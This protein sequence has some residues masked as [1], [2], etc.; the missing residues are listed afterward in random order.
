MTLSAQAAQVLQLIERAGNPEY[1][2]MTAREARAAHESRAGALDMAPDPLSH[3]VDVTLPG[4]GAPRPARV[5]ASHAPGPPLPVVLWL[6]GGGHTVGSVRSYDAVCR[7]LA[8]DSDCLVVSLEYRLAPEHKFPAA[9]DDAWAALEWL[10]RHAGELGGDAGRIAVAGDSAGGNLAAVCALLARD[11]GMAMLRAQVLVYPAVSPHLEFE[12]HRL[13]AE[14]YLLGVQSIRWFQSQYLNHARERTDWRFAPLLAADHGGLA[15]ALVMV[16]GHDPLRDEG[17]AYAHRLQAAGTRVE[18][19]NHADM[20]HAFWSLGGII[21][22]AARSIGRAARF[23]SRELGAAQ[24][25]VRS[26]Q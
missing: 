24:R 1:H 6:H 4:G 5:Y 8:R 16:A 10:A 23:L 13:F 21:D 14:G 12:S 7:R 22:E 9:L 2:H 19:V 26:A 18:L 3:V 11:R 25:A 17:I 20:I 15:P